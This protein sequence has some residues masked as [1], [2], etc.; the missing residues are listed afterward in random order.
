MPGLVALQ[1]KYHRLPCRLQAVMK[2]KN[3]IPKAPIDSSKRVPEKD[4]SGTESIHAIENEIVDEVGRESIEAVE[5]DDKGRNSDEEDRATP[6]DGA[7]R[8][9]LSGDSVR[10]PSRTR[11][12]I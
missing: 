11:R 7:D 6:M 5:R 8:G 9:S 3:R 1:R 12:D 10:G 2:R 4:L